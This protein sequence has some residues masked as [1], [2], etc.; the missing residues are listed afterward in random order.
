MTI[1]QIPDSVQYCVIAAPGKFAGK[2]IS[3]QDIDDY[4]KDWEPMLQTEENMGLHE[5]GLKNH[6]TLKWKEI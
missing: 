4:V 2:V 3:K 5:R 6:F 1:E